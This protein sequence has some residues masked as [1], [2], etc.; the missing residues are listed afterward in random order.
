MLRMMMNEDTS[1]GGTG[2]PDGD[3]SGAPYNVMNST[4]VDVDYDNK[5]DEFD[6]A[7]PGSSAGEPDEFDGAVTRSSVGKKIGGLRY[8]FCW[9][10]NWKIIL[11]KYMG[12]NPSTIFAYD[13]R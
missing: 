7:V 11:L 3:V 13:T 10:I 6:G 4:M 12:L 1:F 9:M 8:E 5:P 2:E